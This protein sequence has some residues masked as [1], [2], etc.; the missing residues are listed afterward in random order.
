MKLIFIII[1]FTYF[2]VH[3]AEIIIQGN[4]RVEASEFSF[5]DKSKYL[6][7]KQI[8]Q[9]TDNLGNY[10]SN[11]CIGLI[12]KDAKEKI[13]FLDVICEYTDQNDMITWRKFDRTGSAIQRGVGISTVIDTTSKYRDQLIG[14]KCSYPV[15]RTKDMVFSKSVCTIKDDLYRKL[16]K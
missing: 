13:N 5:T 6:T 12:K 14:T 3:S 11:K 10:G 15:N 4:A 9:W 1:Y 2:S 8:G 7:V 16:M